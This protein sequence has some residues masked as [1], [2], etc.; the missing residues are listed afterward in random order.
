MSARVL[1]T[2]AEPGAGATAR[3]LAEAGYAPIVEPLFTLEA[4]RADLPASDALAFT[5]TNGVRAFAALS[6]RRDAAVFCVGR[7]TA[8]AAQTA[9][10]TTVASAD[11]DVATLADLIMSQLAPGA[12]LLHT[13]NEDSRGD[14]ARILRSG[15]LNAEFR[16]LYRARP[17]AEPGPALASCLAGQSAFEAVLV[18]SPR[19][20][21]ILAGLL[22]AAPAPAAIKVAAISQQ[23][24]D[25]LL[26]R[27]RRVEIAYSPDEISLF[28]ALARLLP[29]T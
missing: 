20:G 2:R 5:S 17:V 12:R 28:A 3:R 1:V 27:A 10:F 13:G 6:A 8:E 16:A 25:A 4:L 18:H 7:R 14:L 23:A 11:G 21:E 29:R 19:A 26:S 22:A 24:A 15:G 9:G